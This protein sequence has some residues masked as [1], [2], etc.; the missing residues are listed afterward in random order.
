MPAHITAL[1]QPPAWDASTPEP[2]L[3]P[4]ETKAFV[5]TLF[6]GQ[7]GFVNCR[8]I[9]EPPPSA[10]VAHT[11]DKW[12]AIGPALGASVVGFVEECDLNGYGAFLVPAPMAEGGRTAADLLLLPW[13]PIDLDSGDIDAQEV[14]LSAAIG[15]PTI[16]VFSGGTTGDT[17]Q[18]KRH[19]YYRLVEPVSKDDADYRS[20][21]LAL[22]EQ[23]GGDIKVGRSPVQ[24]LRIAGSCHRKKGPKA[25]RLRDA[26]PAAVYALPAISAVLRPAGAPQTSGG[27]DFNFQNDNVSGSQVD[28]VLT[29]PIRAE[30]LDNITRFDGAGVALG[31]FIRQV[32][33]GRMTTEQ[34]WEAAR[35]WNAATMRPAW[36]ED[37][38]RGDFDRLVHIDIETHGPIVPPVP[39]ASDWD[40]S[41]WTGVRFSGAVKPRRWLV[42]G[43]IPA[44]V[45]GT[46]ISPGGAGKTTLALH[47]ALIVACRE[48]AIWRDLTGWSSPLFMG[49]PILERGSVVVFTAEDGIDELTTKLNELDP[50][51][52]WATNQHFHI[53]PVLEL[54]DELF[55]IVA[56]D[57]RKI[58]T[59]SFWDK[60]RQKLAAIP[61]LKLVVLDPLAS[62]IGADMSDNKAAAF[63]MGRMAKLAAA[64]G[65]VV[66]LTHHFSKGYTP[67][68]V[69][70]SEDAGLGAVMWKNN[71]RFQITIWEADEKESRETLKDLGDDRPDHARQVYFSGLSKVN[72]PASGI[73]HTLLR[74]RATGL[75]ED[76]TDKLRNSRPSQEA[77]DQAVFAVLKAKRQTDARFA[78]GSSKGP[79]WRVWRPLLTAAKVPLAQR[80]IEGVF[81]RLVERGLI[82]ETD[83]VSGGA[84][85]YEP[86]LE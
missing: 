65:A 42:D 86:S 13:L 82:V 54:E 33:E 2:L 72:V 4:E 25:V 71:S 3:H 16:R 35:G 8:A 34:A 63:T 22:A 77:R 53:V 32:R 39:M 17:G 67:T 40:L 73:R 76:V 48:P 66:M 78:F 43:L 36:P 60:M 10:G 55:H 85:L 56:E 1:P 31:H 46:L 28:R 74:N 18:P 11:W 62:F 51:R 50:S 75:L 84:R 49:K 68:S 24:L 12:F 70:T 69:S 26:T 6:A 37:R 14:K 79:L 52:R 47:L 83:K 29:A 5:T 61:N 15:E 59:T 23:F 58:G 27:F 7:T 64:T 30:G 38:L 45:P 57:G 80:E 20:A 19:L 41:D 9:Q 81:D 21:R 44:G